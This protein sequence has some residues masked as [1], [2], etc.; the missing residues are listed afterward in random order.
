MGLVKPTRARPCGD[1]KTVVLGQYDRRLNLALILGVM[2]L[3]RNMVPCDKRSWSGVLS[4]YF[5]DHHLWRGSCIRRAGTGEPLDNWD[6]P[7]E[8]HDQRPEHTAPDIHHRA[9][10]AK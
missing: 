5:R 8:S 10:G 9:L 1:G 7:R 3:W 4:R 2:E 6:A